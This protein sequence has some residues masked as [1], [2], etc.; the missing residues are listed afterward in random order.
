MDIS[1]K[2][3]DITLAISCR[4]FCWPASFISISSGWILTSS[5]FQAPVSTRRQENK[6]SVFATQ[7][8][9]VLCEPSTVMALQVKRPRYLPQKRNALMKRTREKT[10]RLPVLDRT[11]T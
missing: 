7:I 10:S 11:F 1:F 8:R 5:S 6:D 4:W 3:A 2:N 9:C